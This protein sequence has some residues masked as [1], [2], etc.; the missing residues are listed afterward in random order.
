M[1]LPATAMLLVSVTPVAIP[2]GEMIHLDPNF[3]KW[4]NST[5]GTKQIS[6]E[7]QSGPSRYKI[8]VDSGKENI[9]KIES[10]DSNIKILPRAKES[11]SFENNIPTGGNRRKGKGTTRAGHRAQRKKLRKALKKINASAGEKGT[12]ELSPEEIAAA[13][14]ALKR[15]PPRPVETKVCLSGTQVTT[16]KI[17]QTLDQL[18]APTTIETTETSS[19]TS[20]TELAT[21]T[22]TVTSKTT[23]KAKASL[24]SKKLRKREG[25]NKGNALRK[26]TNAPATTKVQPSM[27]TQA[28][29]PA[30]SSAAI[31]QLRTSQ[32]TSNGSEVQLS[33]NS[34]FALVHNSSSSTETSLN[35][36]TEVSSA[37]LVGFVKTGISGWF[38][39]SGDK[40]KKLFDSDWMTSAVEGATQSDRFPTL[41]WEANI[42]RKLKRTLKSNW[43]TQAAGAAVGI[44][45]P[46]S[47]DI[48][49]SLDRNKKKKKIPGRSVL[50]L[51]SDKVIKRSPFGQLLY[52]W[53]HGENAI[54]STKQ[55]FAA[56]NATSQN[57]TTSSLSS[58]VSASNVTIAF[59][60]SKSESNSTLQTRTLPVNSS[61][62]EAKRSPGFLEGLFE[63][64]GLDGAKD[65][66]YCFRG[67]KSDVTSFGETLGAHKTLPRCF[68]STEDDQGEFEVVKNSE[69]PKEQRDGAVRLR[70]F[71]V[72]VVAAHLEK[73]VNASKVS[74]A[75]SAQN[76]QTVQRRSALEPAYS[77][78]PQQS[79]VYLRILTLDL[80]QLSLKLEQAANADKP[81]N[82]TVKFQRRAATEPKLSISQSQQKYQGLVHLHGLDLNLETLSLQ[83]EQLINAPN[84][85]QNK[86]TQ[87]HRRAEPP[88]YVQDDVYPKN[89]L[90]N[91]V[92]KGLAL[93]DDDGNFRPHP[94]T[95]GAVAHNNNNGGH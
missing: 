56:V 76:N 57:I 69:P 42:G 48:K 7:G 61:S 63:K 2:A 84:K 32:P 29:K 95:G 1:L 44:G 40:V 13:D 12:N 46:P 54:I 22:K 73:S 3:K 62:A 89:V 15:P 24:K 9:Q 41:T 86:I 49:T 33:L 51:C 26:V 72:N 10:T 59:V 17:T 78:E 36:T 20:E 43:L 39:S 65:L 50:G 71:G 68:N 80:E 45:A 18:P 70:V 52:D 64:L 82:V 35:K 83:L 31:L 6:R 75:S 23:Q 47:T 85:Y 81:N 91:N 4:A 87:S 60:Q 25:R 19:T 77:K 16:V 94:L 55:F 79:L 93:A 30:Q 53:I 74:Y 90:F 37:S 92:P 21:Q 14:E 67:K 8:S 58:D 38:S 28:L 27:A 66:E 34:T 11:P 5:T 88:H